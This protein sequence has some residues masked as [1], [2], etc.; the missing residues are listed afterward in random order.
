MLA[1][2]L[3]AGIQSMVMTPPD[4]TVRPGRP[5]KH[6]CSPGFPES[7][8][9]IEGCAGPAGTHRSS[10]H[11]R[12]QAP[13]SIIHEAQHPRNDKTCK[14][15]SDILKR[16][17]DVPGGTVDKNLPGNAGDMGAIPG[18]RRSHML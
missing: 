9:C 10:S 3:E 1:A 4:I 12:D 2:P 5:G 18:L 13:Q 17:W 8:V 15:K 14:R 16:V 7:C 6:S 11:P